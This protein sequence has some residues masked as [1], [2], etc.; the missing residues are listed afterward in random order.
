MK[1]DKQKAIY[2]QDTLY[3]LLELVVYEVEVKE[4]CF[5][6]ACKNASKYALKQQNNLKENP[7]TN[8]CY[9]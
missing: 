7:Y 3:F 2:K 9:Y 4:D 6:V 8:S 5:D 1:M